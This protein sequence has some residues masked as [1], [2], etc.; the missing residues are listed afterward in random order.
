VRND[1]IFILRESVVKITQMLSGKGIRV[2]QQGVNAYVKVDHNG[3]PVLVNLPYLP[4]N[5]TEELCNAIQG[6][7]D[8]EVAHILFTEFTLMGVANRSGGR[9]VGFLLNALEDPRIEKEMAKRFSGSAYNL[10]NTGKF[11]LDK[12]VVP[13]VQEF[14]SKGDSNGVVQSLMVPM[15]RAM[16]G[17]RVFEE[18]MKDKWA[19]VAVV[20]ERIKDLQPQI[21]GATSTADCLELAKEISKRLSEGGDRKKDE[22][23]ED[24]GSRGKGGESDG[25]GR[26]GK[27]SSSPKGKSEQSESETAPEEASE[28][29]P[30]EGESEEDDKSPPSEK[31][32]PDDK[33]SDS[34][35]KEGEGK[36][37]GDDA[38]D[39]EADEDDSEADEDEAKEEEGDLREADEESD[40]ESDSKGASASTEGE[41]NDEEDELGESKPIW[42][43][44]DKDGTNGFD[45]TMSRAIS[46]TALRSA[47]DADY[48][49]F[50]KDY[51]L[52]EKLPIGSG[53]HP[54]MTRNLIEKVEH[55]VAPLQKDLERAIAA[56]S[57]ATR[58]H[59]HRS[60]RLHA[61]NL[62]RLALNDDRVFSRKHE[63]NSKD[64]AVE[65]V[66]DASGSM[67]GSKIHTASQSAYAL[68]AVLERIGIK[69]EV[70]CFTTKDIGS[71]HV[72]MHKQMADTG[73]RF[74]R[75]EG[76]YMPILK[77]FEERHT[78][79]VKERFGWLPNTNI[80]RSNVDGECV[81]IAA[82]RLLGRREEGKIMI[83]LSDGY[84]AAAGTRAHLESHLI[85]VVKDVTRAGVKVVGIGIESDAVKRF[86][87]K[88]IVLNTVTELPGA[89][90]KEL[91]HLLMN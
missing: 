10:A 20:H 46:E 67:M 15:I 76:L 89:V 31:S 57:L 50:T 25:K 74:S 49:P 81:E 16:S 1:R 87:P 35:E 47:A 84:P 38:D 9:Q 22:K 23:S 51:D 3:T 53:Y 41:F 66:V 71:A 28:G 85:R 83:V 32:K 60:G 30:G 7:L 73:I 12:F 55:M 39:S 2:T 11:Y 48:L 4:D 70:I 45:E 77:G 52:I 82:R 13:R 43:A 69:H 62:S 29:E 24:E 33:K 6:F 26:R 42:E 78:T 59:G 44:L 79:N 56:R 18:F 88:N 17:Q 21:E 36:G 75:Q 86:Y 65:L 61:A 34:D 90:I 68:S 14:A 58:S 5:A 37:E 64:V 19:T 54:S 40:G 91:R 8:H 27:K 80:L 72:D 63:N